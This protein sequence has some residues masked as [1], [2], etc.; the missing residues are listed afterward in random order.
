[1]DLIDEQHDLAVAVRHLLEHSL[2]DK[3]H[4]QRTQ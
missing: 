3:T 1:V 4:R 2:Q